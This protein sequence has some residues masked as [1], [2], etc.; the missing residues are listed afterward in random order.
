MINVEGEGNQ[1]KKQITDLKKSKMINS[2]KNIIGAS[3]MRNHFWCFIK[4][5]IFPTAIYINVIKKINKSYSKKV[6]DS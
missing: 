5:F 4:L 2:N 6:T 3:K 1:E